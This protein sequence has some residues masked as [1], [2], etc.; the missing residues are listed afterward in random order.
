MTNIEDVVKAVALKNR[1]SVAEDDPVMALITIMTQIAYDWQRVMDE[2]LEKHKDDHETLANRWRNDAT[3]RA[4]AMVNATLAAGREAM[5]KGM[6][7]GAEKALELVRQDTREDLRAALAAHEA[8]IAK[9]TEE[10][11]KYVNRL[12]IGSGI[13]LS[14][15]ALLTVLLWR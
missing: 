13:A 12:V 8:G 3:K 7:E 4:E 10:F 6:N 11:K 15:M 9:A 2:S 5:A 14:L 1:Q